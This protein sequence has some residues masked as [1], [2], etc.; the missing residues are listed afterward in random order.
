MVWWISPRAYQTVLYTII[1]QKNSLFTQFLA[2]FFSKMFQIIISLYFFIF[3]N[4]KKIKSNSLVTVWNTLEVVWWL[5]SNHCLTELFLIYQNKHWTIRQLDDHIVIP[6]SNHIKSK[7]DWI[8]EMALCCP[9]FL[10]RF[11]SLRPI[12]SWK[13]T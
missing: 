13:V 3:C 7:I 8:Q 10:G 9:N 2:K 5:T 11:W 4:L 1:L 6:S 12:F